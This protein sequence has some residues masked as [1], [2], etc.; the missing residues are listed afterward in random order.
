M[1]PSVLHVMLPEIVLTIA[2]IAVML[3]DLWI[4][5]GKKAAL[6]WAAVAICVGLFALTFVPEVARGGSVLSDSFVMDP[7]ALFFKR[8]FC[9][10]GFLVFLMS[11]EYVE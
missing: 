1:N 6:G 5:A 8:A 4:P 9:V 2:A 11:R 10:T 3:W 7:L